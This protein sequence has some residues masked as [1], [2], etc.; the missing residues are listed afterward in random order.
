M[1][2][3][4]K[5]PDPLLTMG[6]GVACVFP[7]VE[8]CPIWVPERSI[9]P[10]TARDGPGTTGKEVG[11]SQYPGSS[12]ETQENASL[13]EADIQDNM[14]RP[15]GTGVTGAEPETSRDGTSH[16]STIGGPHMQCP[17]DQ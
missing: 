9:R 11:W 7:R 2:G 8:S 4:W 5:G 10:W 12:E 3:Q 17:D 14:G 13:L 1:S 16:G 15:Q 6:R